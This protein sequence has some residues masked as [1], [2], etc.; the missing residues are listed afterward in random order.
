M[1]LEVT[2]QR[3]K[4]ERE[5]QSNKPSG[6]KVSSGVCNGKLLQSFNMF[7]RNSSMVTSLS[8]CPLVYNSCCTSADQ[9]AIFD[10]WVTDNEK[11]SLDA[12]FGNYTDIFD[13]F[14]HQAK[15]VTHFAAGVLTYM[16]KLDTNECKIMARRILSYQID[17]LETALNEMLENTYNF[18]T[19][20]YKGIYCAMC[21]ANQQVF[22]DS[23]SKKITISQ[24]FC[25]SIIVNSLST[26][27]YLRVHMPNYINLLVTFV[28][29]CDAAGKFVFETISSPIFKTVDITNEKT[30]NACF[31]GRNTNVWLSNCQNICQKW[32]V[33]KIPE[34]F[35][36]DLEQIKYAQKF[37]VE[38]LVY[39]QEAEEDRDEG[40]ILR[41]KDKKQTKK[42]T[43]KIQKKTHGKKYVAKMLKNRSL[44][45]QK[46]TNIAKKSKPH[47]E[48]R[49]QVSNKPE[50]N[51]RERRLQNTNKNSNQNASVM[52]NGYP[53][54]VTNFTSNGTNLTAMAIV[55]AAE[56]VDAKGRLGL[57]ANGL[58]SI[59]YQSQ[60]TSISP[61]L[62]SYV[63]EVS[64]NG[65]DLYHIGFYSLITL[66]AVGD[67]MNEDG[68]NS[69]AMIN[70]A[71][72]L[73]SPRKLKGITALSFIVAYFIGI[74]NLT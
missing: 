55:H 17:D 69:E 48:R 63:V 7:G 22:I 40:R 6:S 39:F 20:S 60:N 3:I 45:S 67:L 41:E 26:L 71:R 23:Q 64:S 44:I 31:K 18:M 61:S 34:F 33:G 2:F 74:L 65:T 35:M 68:L 5:L 52:I 30:L 47:F 42:I 15:K 66:E 59:V 54:N 70:V 43:L 29:N 4:Q 1:L 27:M 8:V 19:Q 10:N 36:P 53:V 38:N 25:R 11:S 72:K 32:G 37:M 13:K 9:V 50:S 21:D 28:G 46:K 73:K 24:S 49:V 12:K 62:S 51:K 57:E 58:S 16:D 56:S 14:L